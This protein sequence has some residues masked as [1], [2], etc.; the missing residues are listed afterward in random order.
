MKRKTEAS[1]ARLGQN[2]IKIL[3][4]VVNKPNIPPDIA[5][6]YK[7]VRLSLYTYDSRSSLRS[8]VLT[9][10]FNRIPLNEIGPF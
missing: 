9:V 6:N 5:A 2:G 8:A 10:I 4:L 3:N 7:Q 1:I